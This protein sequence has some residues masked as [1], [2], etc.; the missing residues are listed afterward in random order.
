MS[1]SLSRRSFLRTGACGLGAAA[2][3]S[4]GLSGCGRLAGGLTREVTDMAGRKVKVPDTIE[5]VFCT[6]PIGT[7]DVYALDSKLLCGWN[8]LPAGDNRAYIDADAL[9][10][11]ALGV[12]MGSGST[13]NAEEIAQQ[14]PDVLLCFWTA[15]DVGADMADSIAEDTGLPVLVVDYDI[16]HLEDAYAFLGELLDR[17]ERADELTDLCRDLLDQA[18]AVAGAVPQD[19]R[20]SVFLAQG[21]DGLTTDPV[22][23]MHVTDALELLDVRNVADMPGTSGQGMGM[24]SV[25]LEQIISWDPVAVLVSE[26]S[27]SNAESSDIYGQIKADPH[28]ANV[29]AVAAGRIYRIPQAPFS[30]FGR[31][32]SA[33]R[34]LGCLWLAS[35]LYPDQA[36]AAG[37]DLRDATRRFYKGFLR[38][39]IPDDRLDALLATALPSVS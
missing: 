24:P 4:L 3:G 8:F 36:A 37:V 30:W 10:L 14:D 32:P 26:Y 33:M 27:M 9:E 19:Q 11:P 34:A 17:E 39:D 5:R 31:P 21:K 29:P 35:A 20:A 38:T 15:D 28:W 16:R 13:P 6:N 23:S 1:F 7:V 18:T 12:W 25:N 2:F 22:G